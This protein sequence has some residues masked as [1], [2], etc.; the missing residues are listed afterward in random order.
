MKERKSN[1]WCVSTG[2]PVSIDAIVWSSFLESSKYFLAVSLSPIDSMSEHG[3]SQRGL[4]YL[5]V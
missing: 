5:F 4:R 1:T 3:W 2:G